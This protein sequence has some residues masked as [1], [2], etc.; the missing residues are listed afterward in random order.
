MQALKD[1][2]IRI[3][4]DVGVI[5]ADDL[6]QSME[7]VPPLS[8]ITYPMYEIGAE[9]CRVFVEAYQQDGRSLINREVKRCFIKRGS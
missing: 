1:A 4:E 6:P 2:G 7:Q 3:P 8:T 5:G 9:L